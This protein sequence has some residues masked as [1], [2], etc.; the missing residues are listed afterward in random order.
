MTRRVQAAFLLLLAATATCRRAAAQD[1]FELH[2]YE[3]ETLR[4]RVW[5]LETHVN[6]VA[7]GTKTFDGGIAPTNN[8]LHVTYELTRGV[9]EDLAIGMM[10]LTGVRPGA[11]ST[12]QFAGWRILPHVKVPAKWRLPV[13]LGLVVEI[14]F[15][16]QQYEENTRQIEIRPIMERNIGKFQF[17]INPVF[18]RGV[19]GQGSHE[20]WTFEPNVRL[21]YAVH[22]R[23]DASLE[24]Y[25]TVGPVHHFPATPNQVHQL[26]PGGDWRVTDHLL[27]NF[28]VGAG[29]TPAGNRVVIKTRF[30][31]QWGR[32]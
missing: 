14:S 13:N 22:R 26:Y 4:P 9:T 18:V 15:Q 5:T 28:G 1:P 3:Y 30:E 27:F 32:G 24:Y 19:R 7:S 10:F 12:M 17:N 29:L 31:Y 6:Y 20:G 23:F 21:G 11:P 25:G 2:V 16:S 8:Q